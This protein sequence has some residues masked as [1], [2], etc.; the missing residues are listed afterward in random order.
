MNGARRDGLMF[1]LLG[2]LVFLLL[3]VAFE[4]IVP[5]PMSDF[6]AIYYGARCVMH[7]QDPYAHGEILRAYVADGGTFPADAV[8]ARSVQRAVL[9]C[10]N[11]PTGLFL[12]APFALLAWGPAHL[13]WLALMAAALMVAA[14]LMWELGAERAPLL[15]GALL[16]LL[17]VN[18]EV[19]MIIGNAAA[20]AIGLCVIASWCFIKDRFAAIGVACM[21]L[22]LLLKPHDAGLIWLY[23]LLAGGTYRK[24]AWQ[25]LI[26]VAVVAV[27]AVLWAT[28]VSPHWIQELHGNLVET[29]A[30][31]DLNDPGPTSLGAHTLGMIV[32]LQT[33]VSYFR[34]DPR[35]YN[36]VTYLICAPLVLA[37]GFITLRA[38]A[39]P[40]RTWLALAS[41]AALSLL[42]LYHR[43][44]DTKLLLL[45]VPA[46]ALLWSEGGLLKWLSLL[47][48]LTGFFFTGDLPWAILFAVFPHLHIATTGFSG[49][50]VMAVQVFP[51]PLALLGMGVFYLWAYARRAAADDLESAAATEI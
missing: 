25:T 12:V 23:F 49:K 24:R 5:G 39:T 4:S 33:V 15:S 2:C 35:F 36:P 26:V 3:G 31:G 9:V 27:P 14:F 46:C 32:S 47:V 30:R 19:V 28:H 42:P 13:L 44:Y 45:T 11:L 38:P 16:A 34:D 43:Q 40:A 29:S 51:V 6:K 8:I 10:I 37:W 7:G 41:I 50:M 22:T 1:L 17:L 21:A 48:N 20:I 18:S